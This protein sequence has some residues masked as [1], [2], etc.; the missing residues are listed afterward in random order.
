MPSPEQP[1]EAP[2]PTS[3]GSGHAFNDPTVA[4]AADAIHTS[5]TTPAPEPPAEPAKKPAKK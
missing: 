5:A 3:I 2:E 4:A 1:Q